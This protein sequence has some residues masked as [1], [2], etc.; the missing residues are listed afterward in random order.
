MSRY[1][2]VSI[3]IKTYSLFLLIC[4]VFRL[5]LFISQLHKVDLSNEATTTILYSFWMGVRF[6][7]VIAGYIMFLPALVLGLMDIINKQVRLIDTI[8]FYLVF[9]ASAL[10]FIVC[11]ADIPFF[12]QF[13]SRFNITAFEWM[14]TPVFV[15]KMIFEEPRYF[16]IL[17]PFL[18]ILLL[19][20]ILLRKVFFKSYS[21]SSRNRPGLM[22]LVTVLML[23]LIFTGV[24][25]RLQKKSPIRVGT[26]YFCTNAFLNQLGLN[27]AFTLMRSYLDSRKDINK[28]VSLMVDAE[29]IQYVQE[30]IPVKPLDP[31][32]PLARQVTPV[33]ISGSRPNVVVIIMECMSA[34]KMGRYGNPYNLTPFLDSLAQQSLSFNNIYSAGIH[35]F[36][37]LFGT[38]FSFPSLFR[39][40]HLKDIKQYN[41]WAYTMRSLGYST[42]YVTTH[43]GQ[44][45]NVEGFFHANDF[46]T[47]ISQKDYPASEVK[48]TLGVPDDFMFRYTLP[49]MD[50]LAETGKPFFI[51]FMTASDHGPYFFPEYFHG[52]NKDDTKRIVEYADWSLRRFITLAAQKAWFDSTIF[53]FVADHGAPI[54]PVYDIS[55]NYH[56]IPFIVYGPGLIRAGSI[57]SIGGQID[58]FPT[59]MGLLNLPYLNNTLGIDLMKEKRPYIYMND[60]NKVGVLDREFFLIFGP[61]REPKLYRYR[62]LDTRNYLIEFSAEAAAMEKYARANMQ[63]FQYMILR[64]KQF[65]RP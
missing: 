5:I 34:A 9:A 53:V 52:K 30:S 19:Y 40:H 10:V 33:T 60:D 29:A 32:F 38:L 13:F 35:T 14:D 42:T 50:Q 55:L 28:T 16:L 59:T 3:I 46:E 15:L 26:A 64:N 17:V 56:H 48:T 11:A 63:V 1:R 51:T 22:V 58:V 24:R 12:N 23:G 7:L 47:V 61:D 65:Y 20:F 8:L 41:G 37:G 44:F 62:E 2:S 6:D 54:Q 4:S 45:D 57:D 49:V 31:E 18:L 27:P 25:G 36:N 21:P 43:D 39:Q